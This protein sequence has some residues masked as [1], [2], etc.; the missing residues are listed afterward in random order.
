MTF[1]EDRHQRMEEQREH[2]PQSPQSRPSPHQQQQ[3]TPDPINNRQQEANQIRQ[4][5]KSNIIVTQERSVMI[6]VC[7]EGCHITNLKIIVQRLHHD[8]HLPKLSELKVGQ[9][10]LRH[11]NKEKFD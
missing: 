7:D 2:Q 11:C 6:F 3:Q 1:V 5:A 9:K 10:V 4:E 8:K